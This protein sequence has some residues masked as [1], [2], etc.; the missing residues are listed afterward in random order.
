M[1]LGEIVWNCV[2]SQRSAGRVLL[3][4]GL[5]VSFF[6][7]YDVSWACMHDQQLRPTVSLILAL[8]EGSF[9][10]LIMI[11]ALFAAIAALLSNAEREAGMLASIAAVMF[12]LR[13][14]L[15]VLFGIP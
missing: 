12:T 15:G 9:G 5:L 6:G 10:A 11:G 14:L 4:A 2:R 1:G 3:L 13:V 7:T 8:I